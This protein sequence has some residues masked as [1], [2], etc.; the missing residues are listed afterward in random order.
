MAEIK[1]MMFATDFSEISDKA[2]DIAGTL[3]RGLG[4]SLDVVHVFDATAFE[5]PA[6]Y[7]FMPGVDKWIDEHFS[8]LKE[9][10]RNALNDMVPDLGEGCHAHFIEGKANRKLVEFARKH[11]IDLIVMGTH[12]HKAFNHLIMGSVAEYVV[13]HAPC[14]V[15]TVKGEL[16]EEE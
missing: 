5:M 14:A 2:R 10:G 7:Y 8:G 6:P 13:R 12:G 9:R 3:K 1:K 15:L 11:D 4:C 16:Q